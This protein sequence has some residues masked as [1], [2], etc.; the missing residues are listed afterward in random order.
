MGTTPRMPDFLIVG[1]AKAGTTAVHAY[2]AQHPEVFVPTKKETNFFAYKDRV[3]HILGPKDSDTLRRLLL[4]SPVTHMDEYL[5][6]FKAALPT[7]RLGEASPRYLYYERSPGLIS[8]FAPKA[9]II[10]LLRNPVDRAYSH[11]LMNKQRGLEPSRNFAQAVEIEQQRIDLGWGWD[12]HYMNLG[13]YAEQIQRYLDFFPRNQVK[14][15]LHDDLRSDLSEVISDLFRYIQVDSTFNVDTSKRYKVASTVG[16]NDGYLGR[17]AFATE[18]TWL[19]R[20]AQNVVP[21]R[22]G[23]EIHR[24]VQD[25]VSSRGAGRRIPKLD[26]ASRELAWSRVADDVSHL[27]SVLRIDLNDWRNMD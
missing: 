23:Q 13:R 15:I 27:E 9:K 10:V 2:L 16:A 17:L 4:K 24:R 1:A 3:P 18:S 7:Q 14:I 20:F 5:A 26:K 11:F 22:L 21:R 25:L 19:G 12:W 6:L 8:E